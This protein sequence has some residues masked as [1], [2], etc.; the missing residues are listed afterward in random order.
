MEIKATSTHIR[1][2]LKVISLSV[3]PVH[4][5]VFKNC[6]LSTRHN[7]KCSNKYTSHL[8]ANRGCTR[9]MRWSTRTCAGSLFSLR[10]AQQWELKEDSWNKLWSQKISKCWQT[11]RLRCIKCHFKATNQHWTCMNA[12]LLWRH[13]I[14][15]KVKCSF[16][17]SHFGKL[18]LRTLLF[19]AQ[20]TGG[21]LHKRP[22][23]KWCM[24]QRSYGAG[25]ARAG[26]PTSGSRENRPR[27][28]VSAGLGKPYLH[29]D[30]PGISLL[31]LCC[32]TASYLL[33]S[34]SITPSS[35]TPAVLGIASAHLIT[36]KNRTLLHCHQSKKSPLSCSAVTGYKHS[37]RKVREKKKNRKTYHDSV[38][39]N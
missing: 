18:L 37:E 24:E 20:N 8:D 35:W 14:R 25:A 2:A 39:L 13:R 31:S 28:T 38:H 19:L 11:R 21:C 10:S 29:A 32:Q 17:N 22:K 36:L 4:I 34:E 7:W 9:R 3:C 30:W 33:L 16:H 15:S 23:H 5:R 12:S 26:T 27:E 1:M 6:P